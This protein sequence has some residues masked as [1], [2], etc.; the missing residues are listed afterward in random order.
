MQKHSW[1]CSL[2]SSLGKTDSSNLKDM[3]CRKVLKVGDKRRNSSVLCGLSDL[4]GV[5]FRGITAKTE[6]G[7][8][9]PLDPI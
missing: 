9:T 5:T 1:F 4:S 2:S 8:Q 3:V 6:D 7:E